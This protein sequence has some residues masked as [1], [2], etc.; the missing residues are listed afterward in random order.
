MT[1][2]TCGSIIDSMRRL[3]L[4]EEAQIGELDA[5]VQHG[6]DDPRELARELMRRDWL[7]A[8]QVNHLLKGLDDQLQLGQY[9]LIHR[10]G[11]GGMGQ[12]FKA[13]HRTLGRIV[14][15]KVIREDAMTNPVAVPRFEREILAAAQLRHPHVVHAFDAGQAD[16]TYY[17]AM[18]FMEGVDLAQ[19]VKQSGP[20][21]VAQ[22]CDYIRQAALG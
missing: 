5:L 6:V 14:A 17:L 20:L 7:S 4:L 8:Y 3:R 13:R 21:P 18:E 10:L 1:L 9:L 2:A 22:A 15:L 12:V 16:G 19:M 11:E